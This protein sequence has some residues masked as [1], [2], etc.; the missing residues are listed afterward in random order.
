MDTQNSLRDLAREAL[1][2]MILD[3][4]LSAGDLIKVISMQEEEEKHDTPRDFVIQVMEDA[5]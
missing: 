4:K 3:S 1:R 5:P 2:Q